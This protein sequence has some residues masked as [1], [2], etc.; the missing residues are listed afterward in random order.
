MKSQDLKNSILQLA[1]QGKLVP[2]DPSDESA[3]KLLKRIREERAELIEQMKIKKPKG[4][5]S[6]IYREG[7]SWYERRGK[8]EPACIDDEIP[9]DIPESWEWARLETVTSYIQRGKSPRYSNIEKYPVVAQKCNQWSG[10]SLKLAKFIDPDTV[11]SYAEE[12]ILRDGDLLWNSTGIGTLGRMAVYDSRVNKYG[13]AVADSHVTVIRTKESWLDFRFAYLYFAGP[14]V[15]LRIEDQASGSTK[16]KELT[17]ETVR[18]YLIPIPPHEEQRRIVEKVDELMPLVEEYGRL[19]GDRE[20]LDAE[21]SDRLRKSVLQLAVQGKLVPQDPS[22]EP[23]GEL[24]ARIRKERAELVKQREIRRPKGGESVIYREGESWYERRGKSERACIDDEIPFDIPESWEW[25]RLETVTSYIQRGK[26]PRYS[27]IEK[28]P[29]VAQKCNQWS[30]FSLK[31]AKFIDPDTVASYAEER[32]LR[33]G[34]LLWNSTG[35]GTLGRMAVYDS[36]VNK[37]GWAV[38]DSHVTV[39]R[40]NESWL[41]FRFA[42]LYFAG[43]S[44]QL[45]IE[46]QASGSTKQKELTQETVR[47]YLIPIPPHE[48]QRRIVEKANTLLELIGT[49]ESWM[50]R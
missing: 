13:W 40:T 20:K 41:D 12:R 7:E 21:L 46:D 50:T 36:R 42:Y 38:A 45:R 25:A 43:P 29:V 8:S 15:Q 14:S 26:S 28:Y 22:D 27:N 10:F 6:V 2:Q 5:E 48:E 34:D 4:G 47:N 16:Q 35:I 17:Q 19:E 30:G 24:L 9:F 3:S 11:A 39:I 31:L 1:V 18:N 37:Y 44:V 32:I 33:D 23:A 49:E